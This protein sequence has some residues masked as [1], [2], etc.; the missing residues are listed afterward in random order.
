SFDR[1]NIVADII[2]VINSINN[3]TIT[4][5][6]SAKNKSGDLLT[7][8]RLSVNNVDTLNNTITNLQKVADIYTIER[9]IK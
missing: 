8:I 9:T 6:S 2:N 4:T 3:V 5:I 7:K 1:R